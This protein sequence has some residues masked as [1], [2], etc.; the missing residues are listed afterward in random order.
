L[1]DK[2]SL[3]N[4]YFK[5]KDENFFHSEIIWV[6]KNLSGGNL[7]NYDFQFPLWA[8]KK[9]KLSECKV[10]LYIGNGNLYAVTII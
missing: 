10:V 8:G 3:Y 5:Q 9:K 6:Y 7:L 1:T 2:P 4:V